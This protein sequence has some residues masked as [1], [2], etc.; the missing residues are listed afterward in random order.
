MFVCS[1]FQEMSIIEI[2]RCLLVGYH[3]ENPELATLINGGGLIS[4]VKSMAIIAISSSYFGIFRKT[5][6]LD[7]IKLWSNVIAQHSTNFAAVLI[8]SIITAALSCN[9][10]LATM[11]T[12]EITNNIVSDSE[13]LA[14]Y[15]ENTVIFV[16]ALIPWSVAATF[17]ILTVDAPI[18]CII[19]GV[20]LYSVPLWNLFISY[21]NIKAFASA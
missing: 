12:Y 8:V 1:Y 21:T 2:L 10:T 5:K 4:M 13:Q 17:P 6:L 11:L 14:V 7:N 19:Y 18:S 16:S 20:Y 3:T 15:L 9:Q